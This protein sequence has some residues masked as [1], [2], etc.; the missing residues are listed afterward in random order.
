[1]AWSRG[2]TSSSG[3][4]LPAEL[5]ERVPVAGEEVEGGAVRVGVHAEGAEDAQLL[6]DDVVGVEVGG[7]LAARAGDDEGAAAA[8]ERQPLRERGRRVGGD[9]DDDVG[10][11]RAGGPPEGGHRVL[12]G[13]VHHQ[14]GAEALGRLE[15]RVVALPGAG[16]HHELGAG[17]LGGRAHAEAADA[18]AQ[19]RHPIAR[20][21]AGQRDPPLDA[22]PERVEHGGQHRIEPVG[23]REQHASRARGTG[24]W[25]SRPTGSAATSVPWN[26]YIVASPW[27]PQCRGSPRRQAPQARGTTG[28]PAR[29]PGRPRCTPQ[30]SAAPGPTASTIPTVSWPGTNGRPGCS[31]PVYCSWSVPHSPHASTR[32]RPSSSPISGSA[33]DCSTRWRGVSSTRAR[34]CVAAFTAAALV[35]TPRVLSARRRAH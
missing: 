18:R 11:A 28:T 12:L 26:P 14:V 2:S 27:R 6:V 23:D 9:V 1:M 34:A 35:T 8:G 29:P 31:W 19:H 30:R 20:R 33:N 10:A 15:A 5:R 17:V 32:R 22:R 7:G 16:D 13:H 4:L 24:G 21:G 25:R 3:D